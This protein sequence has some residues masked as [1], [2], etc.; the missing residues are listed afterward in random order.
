MCQLVVFLLQGQHGPMMLPRLKA[1]PI[2]RTML[3]T[4]GGVS[5]N[6]SPA[7]TVCPP[8]H[9]LSNC[10]SPRHESMVAVLVA[11]ACSRWLYITTYVLRPPPP[12]GPRIWREGCQ[13]AKR[14]GIFFLLHFAESKVGGDMGLTLW[15][16]GQLIVFRCTPVSGLVPGCKPCPVIGEEP[17]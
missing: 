5:R 1:S 4:G 12:Q 7:A 17:F 10:T 16:S 9:A 11:A 3:C 8:Q 13:C 6:L 14:H 2:H 15:R